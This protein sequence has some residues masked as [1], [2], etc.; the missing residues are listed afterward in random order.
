[1]EPSDLIKLVN[2]VA[3]RLGLRYF[4]T[5]SH[6]TVAYGEARFTNDIDIVVDLGPSYVEAFC[7][8]FPTGD[9]YLSRA[10]AAEAV[11]NRGMFNIIHPA[12]G[13]KIDIIVPKR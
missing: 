7:A 3:E 2:D 9:F 6:A 5:G 1:M 8:A 12:S 13:L 4:V 10:A 11:A